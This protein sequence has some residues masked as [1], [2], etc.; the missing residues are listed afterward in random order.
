MDWRQKYEQW[1]HA[2]Q[3]DPEL[4]QLLNQHSDDERWLEDCFYKNLEFGTGG[5]RGEIGPGTNRMNIYTVRKASEG[6]AR[7][8]QSFGDEAKQRGVVIAYDSRHKSPEFAMEAAKTLATNGI[9]TYVFDELRPTPELSFAVRYLRAFAGI[10]I[11]ASHNPPEYNGY[12]VYGE[13]GGQL[14]PA[15]ADQVIRYVNEVENELAIHVEDEKTLREK[16]LIRIIGS[17]VDDAYIHAVKTISIH[18]ELARETAINIVFTPLHG[19]SNKPVRRALAELG[20]QN[21]FVVKEQE[22]PDP[23]FSTVASPNPEEHAAFAMAMELGKQVNADLLIATDPDADRLGVAVKNDKGN[24]VVLTGNQTGGLLLHYLLSQRK[25]QGTLPENGV[26][27]KTIVTSEFGRAIA[28]SFGLETVDTLTG[29]KFIGEKMKEYE[30]TGQYAFQFGYEESYGYLI[31]GFVRDKDAVQAAVLAAEVCAFYKKQGLSLYEALLQ[32]F[33]QYGYYREGQRSLT[34]K[35][36]EGA[37]A[38]AA[39]LAS[40]RQQPPV[41]AAGKKVTVIEDYKTKE[42]TNTLTGEKT[43]IDL[44]TSNVLKYILEDGSWFCLRPSGT[45]PKMK[46]YFG[47]KGIS[48]QDSEEKLARLSDAVMQR[49]HDV[50]RAVSPSYIQ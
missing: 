16:G 22:L 13:D 17:E 45:E 27:L 2:P 32:L 1:L 34:L 43:A 50:L 15:V 21:V 20:Y 6:L 44:P 23:N 29:F 7:Y 33:D 25:A 31:G 42:R 19:T 3:L 46:A 35:G 5:M 37:E 12:K 39:I 40:F 24:Y 41:E 18:P 49:V 14:P 36:K 30:Q 10:V 8:I 4:K 48:L 26:V 9:Q 11:T 28:Q 38:I 47:V